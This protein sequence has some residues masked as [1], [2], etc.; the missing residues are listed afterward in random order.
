MESTLLLDRGFVLPFFASRF[1]NPGSKP[2]PLVGQLHCQ[3]RGIV[4]GYGKL[5]EKNGFSVF[6]LCV[7]IRV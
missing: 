3:S 5:I 2:L 6:S 1:N 4:C 7:R